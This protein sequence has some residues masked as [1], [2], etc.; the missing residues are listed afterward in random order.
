MNEADLRKGID[1]AKSLDKIVLISENQIKYNQSLREKYMEK[2]N[3]QE[4]Q[5][6][7]SLHIFF[8]M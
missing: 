5:N 3:Q 2:Q 4:L 7:K 8:L 1:N 6:S